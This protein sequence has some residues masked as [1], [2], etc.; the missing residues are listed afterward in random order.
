MGHKVRQSTILYSRLRSTLIFV[1]KWIF[2]HLLLHPCL[3]W[4]EGCLKCILLPILRIITREFMDY[5][6][7]NSWQNKARFYRAFSTS[8]SISNSMRWDII[9]PHVSP[10]RFCCHLQWSVH[11]TNHIVDSSMQFLTSNVV[12]G[13]IRY[14]IF[15]AMKR[16]CSQQ[17]PVN[18]YQ[19][20][21]N[22]QLMQKSDFYKD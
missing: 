1:L 14:V 2:F 8:G 15:C 16:F 5:K 19:W 21:K 6:W 17:A 13:Q 22:R 20:T 18:K 3:S 11:C 10:K 9:G 7:I 4:H 12:L